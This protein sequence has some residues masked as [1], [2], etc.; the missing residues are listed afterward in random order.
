MKGRQ[1]PIWLVLLCLLALMTPVAGSAQT[2]PSVLIL[3][4]DRV[5]AESAPAKKLSDLVKVRGTEMRERFTR[6]N[7]DFDA[8]EAEIA[9]VRRGSDPGD[10]EERV[11]DFDRRVR[12]RRQSFRR[13]NEA[14]QKRFADA[15][16]QILD[17]MNPILIS[18][19]EERGAEVMLDAK[20]VLF[21][22][23]QLD[24]TSEVIERLGA[25]DI[26]FEI[27]MPTIDDGG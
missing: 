18:L 12:E 22:R 24:V 14:L 11:R 15:R 4:R 6:I 20:T 19:L 8:E 10:F 13:A 16:Q 25:I 9:A 26:T 2:G 3:D 21:A 23:E 27:E 17:A 5:M 7:A 1:G